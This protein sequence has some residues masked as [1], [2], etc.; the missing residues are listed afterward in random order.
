MNEVRR[1]ILQ[2]VK[3][4]MEGIIEQ[5]KK[6]SQDEAREGSFESKERADVLEGLAAG[7]EAG[8]EVL[9]EQVLDS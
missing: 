1:L 8:V 7:F 9:Q 4:S 3:A 6:V 2:K 5:L